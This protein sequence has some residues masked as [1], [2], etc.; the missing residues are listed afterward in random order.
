VR[1]ERN[2]PA[3]SIGLGIIEFAFVESLYHFDSIRMNS[4][5]AQS[6]NLSDP[7]RKRTPQLDGSGKPFASLKKAL[8]LHE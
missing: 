3:T 1:I 7:Q 4:L 2:A 6:C 5:P 8:E